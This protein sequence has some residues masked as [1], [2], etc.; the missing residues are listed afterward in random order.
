MIAPLDGGADLQGCQI[1]LAASYQNGKE[2]TKWPQSIPNGHKVYQIVTKY[3]K[4]P[5][6]KLSSCILIQMAIKYTN[7]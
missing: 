2:C 5:L 1:F 6:H 4:V 3:T 7:N